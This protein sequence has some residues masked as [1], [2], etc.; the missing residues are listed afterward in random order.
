M[1]KWQLFHFINE[2][3]KSRFKKKTVE[4]EGRFRNVRKKNHK[5]KHSTKCKTESL[6][7]VFIKLKKI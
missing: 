7:G 5:Y 2:Q 1:T 4:L 3:L 6:Q